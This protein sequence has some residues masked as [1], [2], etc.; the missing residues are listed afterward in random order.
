[1]GRRLRFSHLGEAG[2]EDVFGDG[3]VCAGWLLAGKAER[4]EEE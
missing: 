4:R 1:M 3:G 2:A